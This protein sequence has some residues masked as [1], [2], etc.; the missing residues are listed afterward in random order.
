MSGFRKPAPLPGTTAEENFVRGAADPAPPEPQDGRRKTDKPQAPWEN[1]DSDKTRGLN[2][3]LDAELWAKM[4]WLTNTLPK[5]SLQKL[6]KAGTRAYV[7]ALIDEHYY[8][9][10]QP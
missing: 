5:T 8:K 9:K 2:L 10:G 1:L 3:P 6:A 4:H 7:D